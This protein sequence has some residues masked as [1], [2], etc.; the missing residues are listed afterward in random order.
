MASADR[1]RNL[2]APS[3]ER[4]ALV[5][6]VIGAYNAAG[7][8]EETCRSALNQT[9]PALEVIVVDDGST[10]QTADIVESLAASDPRI[11]LIRRPHLGVAAAR[12]CAIAAAAGEFFA[13]LDADDLWHPTKVER[14]VRRLQE[15]G[16]ETAMVYC[17][18]AWIDLEGVVLDR[19]PRW[20]VE[21]RVRDRLVEIN[22]TGCASVPLYRRSCVEAVGGY[23]R[24]LHQRGHQGCEDWDLVIRVAE[25]YAVVV[26]PAVLVGY[27]RLPDSMSAGCQTMWQSQQG[28]LTALADREATV[29]PDLLR[30]SR[31]QFALHLAGLSFWSGRYAESMRWSL[32]V[33]PVSLAVAVAP[34]V[35]SQLTRRLW[36]REPL[37][38]T[39][40]SWNGGV[41]ETSL[42]DPHIPYDQIYAR[43]WK[44]NDSAN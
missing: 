1:H 5:S 7:H 13:P 29:S 4:V 15:Q 31:G 27:R 21:G 30:R 17:W 33:R 34:Y 19:S 10:D 42:R 40:P 2:P 37:Q 11:R 23:D 38:S 44:N 25:R 35:V 43:R 3:S 16:P 32:R 9:Y 26:E 20:R 8:I 39:L 14:Q 41:P 28:M 18:W 22:F 36:R 12:N 24:T 6:V